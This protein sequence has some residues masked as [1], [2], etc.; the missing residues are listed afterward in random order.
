MKEG[1]LI[2]VVYL[3]NGL[4][5]PSNNIIGTLRNSKNVK[6]KEL[7]IGKLYKFNIYKINHKTKKILFSK[8]N[9]IW[10]PNC[11]DYESFVKRNQIMSNIIT[12]LNT[13]ISSEIDK[14]NEGEI[15]DFNLVWN[16]D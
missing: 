4:Y 11:G 8:D 6:E 13:L 1:T 3:G 15:Y 5:T 12:V 2:N 10:V 14:I 7:K 9:E 16:K